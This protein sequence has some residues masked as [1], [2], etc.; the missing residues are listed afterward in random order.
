MYPDVGYSHIGVSAL[1]E[2]SPLQLG[3]PNNI[4]K[5]LSYYSVR[6]YMRLEPVRIDYDVFLERW[7]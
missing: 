7:D 2:P 1:L 3:I 4:W 6:T 5:L